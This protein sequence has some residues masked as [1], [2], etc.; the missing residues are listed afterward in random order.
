MIMYNAVWGSVSQLCPVPPSFLMKLFKMPICSLNTHFHTIATAADMVTEGRKYRVR[1]RDFP[2][3]PAFSRAASTME[4]N[5]PTGTVMTIYFK[6][7]PNERQIVIS[8]RM[9][10]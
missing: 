5:S 9:F 10:L 1:Y 6:V 8:V 2:L 7:L 4:K 3:M